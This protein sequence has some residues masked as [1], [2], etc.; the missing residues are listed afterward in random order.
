MRRLPALLLPLLLIT[1]SPALAQ[2]A[3]PPT[4]PPVMDEVV[5]QLTAE[6]WVETQTALVT[7]TAEAAEAATE[8][9]QARG[10]LL[11]AIDRL[12][13][14]AQWRIVRFDR[15]TDSTGLERWQASAEAR[16]SEDSLTGLA[17][18]AKQASPPG[19]QLRVDANEDTP[20][21]AEIEAVRARLRADIYRR[22]EDEIAALDQAFEGRSFRIGSV[23]F[24][25]GDGPGP[26]P[27]PAQMMARG[28]EAAMQSDAKQAAV[29]VNDKLTLSARVVLSA[30]APRH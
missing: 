2:T 6:D 12:A 26:V 9:G 4:H 14:D 29:S 22:A 13:P 1:S 23:H 5:L 11:A 18:N 24:S 3:L 20:T 30:L 19:L 7:V 16:L 28:A 10:D 27:Y 15:Y 25:E 21:L 8:A 17:Y